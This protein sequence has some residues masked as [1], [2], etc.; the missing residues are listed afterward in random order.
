MGLVSQAATRA[1]M[2]ANLII[3]E[4]SG[5]SLSVLLSPYSSRHIFA[6]VVNYILLWTISK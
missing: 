3:K 1:L 6:D 4:M 2:L 5:H